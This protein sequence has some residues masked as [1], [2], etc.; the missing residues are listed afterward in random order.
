MREFEH[1]GYCLMKG[2]K[3]LETSEKYPK[4]M[5]W[6]KSELKTCLVGSYLENAKVTRVFIEVVL[7]E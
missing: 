7:N 1:I 6:K 3:I 5:F 2:K 4:R